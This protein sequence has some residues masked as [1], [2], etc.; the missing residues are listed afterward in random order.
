MRIGVISILKGDKRSQSSGLAN[1][2][3]EWKPR[4]YCAA[5]RSRN[6]LCSLADLI[7]SPIEKGG[8]EAVV[9]AT[10]ELYAA[11]EQVGIY[12]VFQC[13]VVVTLKVGSR[14]TKSERI[15]R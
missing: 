7:I 4:E 5:G 3:I 15:V 13:V 10:C 12:S 2:S 9:F 6:L 1:S 11:L 8:F 14:R